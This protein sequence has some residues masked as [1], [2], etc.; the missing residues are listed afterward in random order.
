LIRKRQFLRATTFAFRGEPFAE[1]GR[2]LSALRRTGGARADATARILT[3]LL[4]FDSVHSV[5][6]DVPL[7][8]VKE[9]VLFVF[10]PNLAICIPS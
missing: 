5:E 8:F 3:A 4:C 7:E 10:A 2:G 6:N 1:L 9:A